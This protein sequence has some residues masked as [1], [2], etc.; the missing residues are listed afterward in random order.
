M[1]PISLFSLFLLFIPFCCFGVIFLGVFGLIL[2]TIF[3]RFQPYSA[4]EK[5]KSESEARGIL[6][7]AVPDLLPWSREAFPDLAAE[8]EG[9]YRRFLSFFASGRCTSL[10]DSK[11]GWLAFVLNFRG[12][13]GFVLA[14]TSNREARLMREQ[15]PCRCR[16]NPTS[17]M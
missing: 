14:R 12:N 6:D 4:E 8:W 3:R 9:T 15:S 7:G 1:D 11:R 10:R 17:S 13:S 16:T 2:W 5:S